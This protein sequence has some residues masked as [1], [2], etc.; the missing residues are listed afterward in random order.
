MVR[1]GGGTLLN[2]IDGSI[3]G[4][5]DQ[6]APLLP[7][8]SDMMVDAFVH[9]RVSEFAASQKGAAKTRADALLANLESYLPSV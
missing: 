5:A 6:P 1:A 3:V 9:G 2:L 8:P 7:E 4:Q